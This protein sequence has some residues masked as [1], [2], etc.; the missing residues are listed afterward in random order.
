VTKTVA[1]LLRKPPPRKSKAGEGDHVLVE[2]VALDGLRDLARRLV[3]ALERR[4]VRQEHRRDVEA[5]VL[6]RHERA[7]RRAPQLRGQR[8]PCPRT[9]ARRRAAPEHEAHAARVAVRDAAEPAVERL[10]EAARLVC[11]RFRM[12][13]HSDGVSVSATK[14]EMHHGD[15]DGHRELAVQLARQ[16]A[17]ERDGHEHGAQHEHDGDDRARDF[18]AWP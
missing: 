11:S 1:A 16:A 17:Q 8:P 2:G 14:P 12:S 18:A 3:G 6:V 10:E 4:A 5:L 13:T 9:A 7:G 15:R